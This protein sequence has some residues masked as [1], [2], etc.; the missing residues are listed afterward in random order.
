MFEGSWRTNLDRQKGAWIFIPGLQ[1]R[2]IPLALKTD[3][4]KALERAQG[5]ESHIGQSLISERDGLGATAACA[6]QIGGI[7]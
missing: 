2:D 6:R 3:E 1:A 7:V 4:H 5:I